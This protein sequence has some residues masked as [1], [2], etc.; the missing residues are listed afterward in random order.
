MLASS[1]LS[2]EVNRRMS[3]IT[4]LSEER[5]ALSAVISPAKIAIN[6][7]AVTNHLFL[8]LSDLVLGAGVTSSFFAV[9]ACSQRISVS[10]L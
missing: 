1:R 9:V 5:G 8:G 3:L 2:V 4:K 6:K 10:K 7:Q